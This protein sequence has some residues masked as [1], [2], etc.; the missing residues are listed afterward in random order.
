MFRY[1]DALKIIEKATRDVEFTNK[2]DPNC[3][4]CI[5]WTLS[6][7]FQP[8]ILILADCGPE[9]KVHRSSEIPGCAE[10]N[11]EGTTGI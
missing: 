10:I 1:P 6:R 9:M 11:E 4:N 7:R 2:I 5:I 3:I 8:N